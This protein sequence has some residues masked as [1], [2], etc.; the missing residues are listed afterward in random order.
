MDC[1]NG[2]T[3]QDIVRFSLILVPIRCGTPETNWFI[4]GL[5]IVSIRINS[6]GLIIFTM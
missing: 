6:Y 3:D 2:I 4:D 1:F 5:I